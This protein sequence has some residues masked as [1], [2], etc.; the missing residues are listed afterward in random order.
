MRLS[1]QS[2]TLAFTL[3]ELLIS[4]G[5]LLAL[6]SLAI[7]AA[8]HLTAEMK[9]DSE[10]HQLFSA[11]NYAR[12]EAIKRG[13]YVTLCKSRDFTHCSGDWSEGY[14]VF[15]DVEQKHQVRDPRFI[16]RAHQ[17]KHGGQLTLRAFPSSDYL[18]MSP[19]GFNRQQNGTFSY[20]TGKEKKAITR[21]LVISTTGRA[22]LKS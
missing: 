12:G 1:T 2:Y 20:Q 18:Q 10:I 15:V 7:P 14:I 4:M 16:L 9:A 13:Q 6:S 21:K 22:R 8:Y 5:I 11:I 19:H 17:L 3:L